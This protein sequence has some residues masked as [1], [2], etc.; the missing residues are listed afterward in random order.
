MDSIKTSLEAVLP[1]EAMALLAN[2]T[3]LYVTAASFLIC[4]LACCRIFSKAGYNG[5]LGLLLLVPAVNIFAFLMLAFSRW[6]I[7]RE[8]RDLRPVQNA[9]HRADNRRLRRA[10]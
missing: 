2:T 3:F 6:P 1:P 10:A 9:V 4:A 8:L 5:A 7:E